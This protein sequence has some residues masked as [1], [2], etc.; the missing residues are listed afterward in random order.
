MKD[1]L[2]ID[3][4]PSNE[5]CTQ[6]GDPDYYGKARAEGKRMIVQID[7]HYPL[8]EGAS[9]G[10]TIIK[11]ESHDFGSYYQIKIIFDDECELSTNWAYSIEADTLH[12]LEYW[13]EIETA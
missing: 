10:Y 4:T 8:P 1:Y 6:V 11:S 9:M 2:Y 7:K 13:D 5:S 12:A 3:T